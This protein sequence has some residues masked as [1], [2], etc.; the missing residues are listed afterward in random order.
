MH[1]LSPLSGL[2]VHTNHDLAIKAD[3]QNCS[4]FNN[5]AALL[6]LGRKCIKSAVQCFE[7]GMSTLRDQPANHALFHNAALLHRANH[8]HS[9]ATLYRGR[10]LSASHQRTAV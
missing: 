6:L 4:A 3:T 7:D 9:L 5:R 1:L 2:C 10:F 8:N